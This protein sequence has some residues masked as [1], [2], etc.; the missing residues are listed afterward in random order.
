MKDR[1]P[2]S[3]DELTLAVG[4][5]IFELKALVDDAELHLDIDRPLDASL[6]IPILEAMLLHLRNLIEFLFNNTPGE[7]AIAA[8]GFCPGWKSQSAATS[9][10]YQRSVQ[11]DLNSQLSHLTWDRVIDRH[12]MP[13]W[14]WWTPTIAVVD[15][16]I[17]FTQGLP[18]D[19]RRPF[20]V[21]ASRSVERIAALP[22][23]GESHWTAKRHR[24][25]RS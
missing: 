19:L 18:D 6:S 16:F 5:I 17:R 3:P 24:T 10:G 15:A 14:D 22:K 4:H 11:G 23:I 7:R 9:T 21:E 8:T 13:E 20:I 2:T 25:L 12:G 1:Q